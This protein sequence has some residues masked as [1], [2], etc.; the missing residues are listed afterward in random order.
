MD[1]EAAAQRQRQPKKK[2]RERGRE[3]RSHKT[4]NRP[5]TKKTY[6]KMLKRQKR[7]EEVPTTAVA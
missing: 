5:H 1:G 6:K 4:T 2:M 3:L 7:T